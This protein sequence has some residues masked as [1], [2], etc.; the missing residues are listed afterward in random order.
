MNQESY[1]I[2][3]RVYNTFQNINQELILNSNK[4]YLFDLSYLAILS[5]EG[6][7]AE[8]FLQGQ[9]TCDVRD[10]NHTTMRQ[11][12][13]CNLKG[14]IQALLDIVKSTTYQL[15]LPTDLI[16]DT[17]TSLSKVAMLSRVQ[18]S[19]KNNYKV[20]GFYLGNKHDKLLPKTHLP[21]EKYGLSINENGYC[22]CIDG[23]HFI[24]ISSIANQDALTAPFISNQQFCGSLA[25]HYLRIK[26]AKVEIYPNTR[27]LF[28]PHRLELHNQGYINFNKG[29]Y[30]GQEIIARTHYRAKLKHHLAVF[31]IKIEQPF[32]AG[33]KLFDES[34]QREVGEV[35][36]YCPL[37]TDGEFLI[38]ASIL[39]DH[40]NKVIIAGQ[41]QPITLEKR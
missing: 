31:T 24:I 3:T 37:S 12:A 17:Q 5:I 20:Y 14:R 29:C 25:W 2:N 36:D 13:L 26:Q 18:L 23:S 10:I 30:K 21:T 16:A 27:G 41:Q 32:N 38:A 40:P 9:L 22:Y 33:D 6:N 15:I 1:V 39:H 28:L 4:N 35:I 11:G 19:I 34:A 7:Q 8:S